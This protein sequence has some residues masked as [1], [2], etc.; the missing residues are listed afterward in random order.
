M[1]IESHCYSKYMSCKDF[2]FGIIGHVFF[3]ITV[4]FILCLVFLMTAFHSGTRAHPVNHIHSRMWPI[5]RAL[6]SRTFYTGWASSVIFCDSRTSLH[7]VQIHS[8]WMYVTFGLCVWGCV[9]L[10][11][12]LRE[13]VLVMILI[14]KLCDIQWRNPKGV[15]CAIYTYTMVLK[16]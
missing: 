13:D 14:K 11:W 10:S 3:E 5:T 1:E 15:E 2:S 16:G 7:R 12:L 4:F 9:Q 8:V 6:I